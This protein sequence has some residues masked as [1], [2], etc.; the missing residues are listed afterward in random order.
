[1]VKIKPS[2]FFPIATDRVHV[3]AGWSVPRLSGLFGSTSKVTSSIIGMDI[4]RENKNPSYFL[5]ICGQYSLRHPPTGIDSC[6]IVIF[7][8]GVKGNTL[9]NL[10]STDLSKM[11]GIAAW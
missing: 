7:R 11:A 10:R 3:D 4:V 6:E 5:I 2:A 8:R 1:M 9:V